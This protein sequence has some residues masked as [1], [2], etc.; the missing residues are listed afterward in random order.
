[1]PAVT[2]L[3]QRMA[4][5]MDIGVEMVRPMVMMMMLVPMVLYVVMGGAWQCMAFM[6]SNMF[7][8]IVTCDT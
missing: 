4:M 5:M 2:T 1:M 6:A 3:L 7:G 8:W